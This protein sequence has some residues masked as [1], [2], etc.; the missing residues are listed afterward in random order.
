M[1]STQE[2]R[3]DQEKTNV[4]KREKE[5]HLRSGML[6]TQEYR[7]PMS[8]VIARSW[9]F[10]SRSRRSNSAQMPGGFVQAQVQVQVGWVAASAGVLWIRWHAASGSAEAARLPQ[11]Q[12]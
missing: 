2:C 7:S 3:A 11:S 6:S 8:Y 9:G 12:T 5:A 1:L 4:K 10:S